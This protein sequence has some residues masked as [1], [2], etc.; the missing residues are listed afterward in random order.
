MKG[1]RSGGVRIALTAC[2]PCRC[3]YET[4]PGGRDCP[5]CGARCVTAVVILPRDCA[6]P[7]AAAAALLGCLS[8]M[9]ALAAER[10]AR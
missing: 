4:V 1:K 5:T 8:S 9:R 10:S 6:S 2:E 7:E 3:T